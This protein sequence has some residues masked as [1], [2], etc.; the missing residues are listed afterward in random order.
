MGIALLNRYRGDPFFRTE[1]NVIV[2]Q[3]AFGLVLLGLVA[4]FFNALY[5][6]IGE[7]ILSGIASGIG[8][9]SSPEILS[10]A[11]VARIEEIR[12]SN[13]L[14]ISL[15]FFGAT[16]LCGWLVARVTLSPARNALAAQKQF[17]GNIAHEIRTP[18]SVIKTNTE[19]TLLDPSLTADVKQALHSN[20]EELDRISEIINNLL[21]LSALMKPE[22]IEFKTVDLGAIAEETIQKISSLAKT[23][24]IEIVLRKGDGT[25]VWGSHTAL[26]QIFGNVVKN[27]LMYTPH[28]GRVEVTVEP[29]GSSVRFMVEDTGIGIPRKDLYRIFEPFY[30]T[31]QSRTRSLGGTG[32]G[33]AIVSE[34]VKLHQGKII[35]RS[36]VGRGTSVTILFPAPERH[37]QVG[38]KELNDGHHEIAVDFSKH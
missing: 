9:K 11:I 10:S 15:I 1:I 22:R 31:D 8:N 21:S 14:M 30:R 19:V 18:L 36:S 7:A 25:T 33:L 28:G 17:I 35:I 37:A 24:E 26:L 4:V 6:Q 12:T 34:L 16:G 5:H 27:A 32:L 29:S 13:F 20:V 3:C 2:L 23:N 38:G